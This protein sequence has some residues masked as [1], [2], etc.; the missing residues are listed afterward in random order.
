MQIINNPV[1]GIATIYYAW[2]MTNQNINQHGVQTTGLGVMIGRCSLDSQ[3]EGPGQHPM[4]V[5]CS[6]LSY[7]NDSSF[8]YTNDEQ[9]DHS[10]RR[11]QRWKWTEEVK[12][13]ALY[14]YFR[15]IPGKRGYRKTMI[16]TLT[17]FSKF[18]TR[19][20][21]L[22]DKDWRITKN[23]WLSDLDISEIYQQICRQTH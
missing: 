9:I 8:R 14:C 2:K 5:C 18:Q 7:T 20:Q 11:P 13:L 12:K 10:Y 6:S 19:N 15:S 22:I 4:N 16:E 17:E 1:S 21:R 3:H 23:S